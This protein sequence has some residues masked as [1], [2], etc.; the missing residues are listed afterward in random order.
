M[1]INFYTLFLIA[2]PDWAALCTIPKC[3][4]GNYFCNCHASV[5]K[6]MEIKL[7]K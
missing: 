5:V 3:F 4:I 1:V 7:M 6:H 2:F